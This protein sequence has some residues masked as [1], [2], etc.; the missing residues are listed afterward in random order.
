MLIN[1]WPEGVQLFMMRLFFLRI[2]VP[3]KWFAGKLGTHK[4]VF[5]A[6][7][8]AV[9]QGK[10]AVEIVLRQKGDADQ[11]QIVQHINLAVLLQGIGRDDAVFAQAA[12]NR[13]GRNQ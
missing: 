10:Q 1:Q 5:A 2:N 3:E 11:L 13:F 12:D 8:Q 6:N 7:N 4:A 9:A